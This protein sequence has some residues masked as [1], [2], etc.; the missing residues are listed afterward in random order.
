MNADKPIESPEFDLFRRDELANKIAKLI[1]EKNSGES[2]VIGLYGKWG[3]GKSSLLNL[4]ACSEFLK[5]R[6]ENHII[7]RYNPWL[8]SSK[9]QIISEFFKEIISS[10]RKNEDPIEKSKKEKVEA[11]FRKNILRKKV[12]LETD[13]E[14]IGLLVSSL[15]KGTPFVGEGLASLGGKLIP[16]I[17]KLHERLVE[18][19]KNENK[20]IIIFI[21]DIDRLEDDE[22]YLIFKLVKLFGNLPG[23]NYVLSFDRDMVAKQINSR[24]GGDGG[25]EFL[26]KIIQLPVHL[27]PLSIIEYCDFWFDELKKAFGENGLSPENEERV[28]NVLGNRLYRPEFSIRL[29]LKH[30]NAIRF[31]NLSLKGE[32]DP[33]DL[34][35]IEFVRLL[36]PELHSNIFASESVIFGLGAS[37]PSIIADIGSDEA[38]KQ[39]HDSL[40]IDDCVKEKEF[41]YYADLILFLLP[42]IAWAFNES[43]STKDEAAMIESL[44][45]GAQVHFSKYFK[46][47]TRTGM[48]SEAE[49]KVLLDAWFGNG[50]YLKILDELIRKYSASELIARF[51]IS[52]GELKEEMLPNLIQSFA[53][54]AKNIELEDLSNG[55]E[56]HLVNRAASNLL[57]AIDELATKNQKL[58]SLTRVLER[59]NSF[60]FSLQLLEITTKLSKDIDEV[61]SSK[62]FEILYS[63]WLTKIVVELGFEEFLNLREGR[64][65]F[66]MS[67]WY[68]FDA[69]RVKHILSDYLS[70][71]STRMSEFVYRLTPNVL[72]VSSVREIAKM[73]IDE[74]MFQAWS[75]WLPVKT[76]IANLELEYGPALKESSVVGRNHEAEIDVKL[77]LARQFYRQYSI[78]RSV[79]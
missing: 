70:N 43:P 2:L 60:D 46:M 49:Y 54:T 16:S 76:I 9:Q 13:L 50:D 6:R 23:V 25:G 36:N 52:R 28:N 58:D 44:R 37:I 69:G 71:S 39:V 41:Q 12:G 57:T 4:I 17:S 40:R 29:V 14:S 18:L 30:A 11:W 3:T 51:R 79:K 61:F 7:I 74:S 56:I 24:F 75:E 62:A 31:A 1:S 27:P 8:F 35:V 32:V 10:L 45:I 21:D 77:N 34:I 20:N 19:L 59:S 15:A 55:R 53:V 78:D 33:V 64:L 47:T 66:L 38:I 68:K 26:E 42:T 67:N 63:Q 73:D 5:S 65:I 48:L 22:V 72:R